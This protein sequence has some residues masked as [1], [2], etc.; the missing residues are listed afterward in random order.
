VLVCMY[1]CMYVCKS[2][3]RTSGKLTKS[4]GVC[5]CVC[6]Y[7]CMYECLLHVREADERLGGVLVCIYVRFEYPHLCFYLSVRVS[8]RCSF[9]LDALLYKFGSRLVFLRTK[10]RRTAH[11]Y[12][13]D[14]PIQLLKKTALR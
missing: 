7:V 10:H 11:G 12:H 6:R 14:T 13:G 1:V 8:V 9:I 2:V 3:F 5:L 4:W